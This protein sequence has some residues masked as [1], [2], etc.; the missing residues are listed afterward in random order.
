MLFFAVLMPL[1]VP[2]LFFFVPVLAPP[3]AGAASTMG[4]LGALAIER[5]T[6]AAPVAAPV[7]ASV[8][9]PA[10]V[11][12][13]VDGEED[14]DKDEIFFFV[15]FFSPVFVALSAL[16][17]DLDAFWFD[18]AAAG[19]LAPMDRL[20]ST[21]EAVSREMFERSGLSGGVPNAITPSPP[22]SSL[23]A[24]MYPGLVPP[25]VWKVD[26]AA[27]TILSSM[28]D[29]LC[30]PSP[31]PSPSPS[32]PPPVAL[33]VRL[34]EY[35]ASKGAERSSSSLSRTRSTVGS[36]SMSAKASALSS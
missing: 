17:A 24:S 9:A 18:V 22:A 20:F 29:L 30:M 4:V 23:L 1:P 2:A 12:V 26:S 33:P 13:G 19:V 7:A 16:E 3:L 34:P 8:A 21:L 5:A 35:E 28:A 32:L 27:L 31:S 10:A 6:V 36:S 11:G 14:E 25:T 15:N